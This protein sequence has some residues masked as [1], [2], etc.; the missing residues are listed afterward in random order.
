MS[1]AAIFEAH[2]ADRQAEAARVAVVGALAAATMLFASLVSAYLVRRSFADWRANEA[3]WPAA[4]LACAVV[5]SAGVEAAGRAGAD[6]R[7]RLGL[8]VLGL[9]SASY[10]AGALAVIASTIAGPSGLASPH[11]AFVVLLL[12]AH[13][14]H[15]TLGMAFASSMFRGSVG[16]ALP[17]VRLVTHFLTLM[18]FGI[19][20]VLFVLR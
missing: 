13:A 2:A 18:L 9:F 15:A 19:V 6:G 10:L 4:L 12:G 20:F 3:L 5:A 8:R 14:A 7:R 16:T 1:R 11:D 17:L